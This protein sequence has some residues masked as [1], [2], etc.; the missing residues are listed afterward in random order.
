[1]VWVS[2]VNSTSLIHY[3]DAN[4]CSP[5]DVANFTCAA[6]KYTQVVATICLVCVR[7]DVTVVFLKVYHMYAHVFTYK[8]ILCELYSCIM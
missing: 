2:L 1:M 3:T 8:C 6:Y 7:A 5:R 4:V